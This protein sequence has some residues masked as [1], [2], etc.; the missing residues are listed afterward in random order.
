[1][2]YQ[3]A[4]QFIEYRKQRF[5]RKVPSI[6][7]YML[8]LYDKLY[9]NYMNNIQRRFIVTRWKRTRK[10]EQMTYPLKLK[11]YFFE[12][13][14][15]IIKSSMKQVKN[16]K[17]AFWAPTSKQQCGYHVVC[18]VGCNFQTYNKKIQ[19]KSENKKQEKIQNS[20]NNKTVWE[21]S[22]ITKDRLK[23]MMRYDDAQ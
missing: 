15:S 21:D 14:R 7:E 2:I 17:L 18:H 9:S 13:V 10:R 23:I 4:V 1:M 6:H 19:D 8:E 11:K 5:E 12:V 20:I 22:N 3:S 16:M